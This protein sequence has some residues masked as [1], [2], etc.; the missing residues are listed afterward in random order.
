M[1]KRGIVLSLL[2]FWKIILP[3]DNKNEHFINQVKDCNLKTGQIVQIDN[4]NK[5]CFSGKKVQRMEIL[6]K[7]LFVHK[8]NIYEISTIGFGSGADNICSKNCI[9]KKNEKVIS[10]SQ[11]IIELYKNNVGPITYIIDI[12]VNNKNYK[13]TTSLFTNLMFTYDIFGNKLCTNTQTCNLE[14]IT[15]E[16]ENIER[17]NQY[18]TEDRK[19][20]IIKMEQK[21][22]K[23][24]NRKDILREKEIKKREE[25]KR[26][27]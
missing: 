25:Y 10:N 7:A 9:T 4:N 17:E 15:D 23:K 26:K 20:K 27:R 11:N 13:V 19:R 21:K 12:N 18:L 14:T 22:I 5:L 16:I 1:T 2:N 24:K 6:R 8:K 3:M